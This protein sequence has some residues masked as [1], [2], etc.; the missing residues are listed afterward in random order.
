MK[1]L[2]RTKIYLPMAA[3][4]LTATLA[5]PAAAQQEVPFKG[6]FQGSDTVAFPMLTQ[7][8]TSGIGTL[9]GQFSATITLTLTPSGAGTG[10]GTW[11]AA[12]GDTIVTTA[13]GMG[14]GVVPMALCQVVGAQPDD[15]YFK[16]T[17]FHT[18]TGGTGR[19]AGVQGMFKLTIYHDVVPRSDGTHGTCGSYSGTIT[20]PSVAH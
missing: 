9:V 19:F 13:S 14:E 1:T 16:S 3:L 11:I 7:N 17:V 5:L 8:I 6:T 2:T 10:T 18:I 15:S 20:P 4:I 12:N